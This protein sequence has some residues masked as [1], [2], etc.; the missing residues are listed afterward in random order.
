MRKLKI[1]FIGCGRLATQLSSAMHSAGFHIV[2]VYSQTEASASRMAET[3]HCAYTT[4]AEAITTEAD[5]YICAL[6]DSVISKVLDQTGKR[7]SGKIL[8]HTAGS[9]PMNVLRK[10][11]DEI[12]VFYPLQTFSKDKKVD[13]SK[14]PFLIEG[15]TS[16]VEFTLK[17]VAS[18]LSTHIY[19]VSSE[20]REK[21]HLAAVFVSNF[22]N[23][24]YALGAKLV[25][26]F[27]LPFS[28]LLPLIDETAEK[29][30]HLSPIEAQSGPAVR[31]DE[32]VMEKHRAMLEENSMER[33]VYDIMSES[34]QELAKTGK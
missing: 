24:A 25:E 3:L 33:K 1:C 27:G 30:H 14:V 28:V 13:F 10:Y 19:N 32:N 7:L 4:Q 31:G 18:Q 6:K 15:S 17:E 26:N 16:N 23:H 8:A 5:L 2:Q 11:S 20:D 22:A 9:I 34:I 12:G 21:V 29:V